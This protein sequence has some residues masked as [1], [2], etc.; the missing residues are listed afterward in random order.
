MYK[1]KLGILFVLHTMDTFFLVSI[2]IH[3]ETKTALDIFQQQKNLK[4]LVRNWF[5]K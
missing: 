3:I 5:V 1:L 4:N 2:K